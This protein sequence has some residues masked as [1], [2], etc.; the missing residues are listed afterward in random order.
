MLSAFDFF[1]G[2]FKDSFWDLNKIKINIEQK[3]K[4]KHSRR[5]CVYVWFHNHKTLRFITAK[6]VVK[7]N[8]E[9]FFH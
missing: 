1:K 6:S 4:K 8:L 3:G 5:E 2:G 9:I 7:F